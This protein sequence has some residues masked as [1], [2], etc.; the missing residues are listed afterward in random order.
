[1]DIALAMLELLPNAKW[2]CRGENYEDL[3]M[4]DETPIP[5]LLELESAWL[6]VEIAQSKA[7][8][9]AETTEAYNADVATLVGSTDQYELTSWSIQESEARAYVAN[10]KAI[11]PLLS[12]M[13]AARGLGETV[14]QFSNLIIANADA[15]RS[16][17]A[18]IL[19]TYQAKQKAINV[20]TTVA[21]VQAI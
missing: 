21:E 4:L 12:G 18:T 19:G 13:V 20:A 11:T 3:E 9:L 2:I 10:N 8:K 6:I 5:S 15:Y 16:A 14:L 7:I 17:Y 1:M